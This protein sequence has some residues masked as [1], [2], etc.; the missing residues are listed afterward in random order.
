[1]VSPGGDTKR[2]FSIFLN[3]ILIGKTMKPIGGIIASL[4]AWIVLANPSA[5]IVYTIDRT[6]AAGSVSGSIT[7]DGTIG[8]LAA[9][10]L[11]D[12]TLL[13]DNGTTTFNLLGPLSGANS[14]VTVDGTAFTATV[15]A[16]L[17]NFDA[18]GF[19]NVLFQES[20]IGTGG[21]HWC[22][23]GAI[24][25]TT[26]PAELIGGFPSG[27]QLEPFLAGVHTIGTVADSVPEPGALAIFGLG[28]I[29]VGFIR[30]RRN[31]S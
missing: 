23:N 22:F 21:A 7:T 20:P 8:V 1:L 9:A 26:F 30:R 24:G 27:G 17:F 15:T 13:L 4:L 16:L 11:T 14:E 6:I 5:A 18:T 28:V 31:V 12:W 29:G 2:K 10:N 19:T 3:A 25:C